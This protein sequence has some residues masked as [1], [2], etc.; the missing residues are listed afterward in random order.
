MERPYSGGSEGSQKELLKDPR[1]FGRAQRPSAQLPLTWDGPLQHPGR[2]RLLPEDGPVVVLVH[3]HDLQVR[4]LLQSGSSP[5]Q[6]KGPQLAKQRA[7]AAAVPPDVGGPHQAERRGGRCQHR[8]RWKM[9]ANR[10]ETARG[11]VCPRQ[12]QRPCP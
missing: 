1:A 6:S 12:R 5:V 11:G 10:G 7:R 8:A 3:D 4:G 9:P 2:E